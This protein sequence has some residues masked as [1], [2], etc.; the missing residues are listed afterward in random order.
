MTINQ[1]VGPPIG[2]ALFA[3]GMALPF[4]GQAVLVAMGAVL[5]SRIV[6]PRVARDP[7]PR[8]RC[9][10]RSP[11]ASAGSGITPRCGRWC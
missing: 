11:R 9:A 3:L 4:V 8:G 10:T 5:V 7:R 2:A 1:L 6:L